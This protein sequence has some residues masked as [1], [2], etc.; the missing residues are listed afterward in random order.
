M[1][2]SYPND[3]DAVNAAIEKCAG[4]CDQEV[5]RLPAK[6]YSHIR[7]EISALAMK[8][9]A[10]KDRGVIQTRKPLPSERADLNKQINTAIEKCASL[11]DRESESF[12]ESARSHDE[13]GNLEEA[14][15][16]FRIC[17]AIRLLSKKMRGMKE[18]V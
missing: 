3:A 1:P 17:D 15:L 8:I 18:A 16:H 6:S 10:L 5:E 12:D 9:R 7:D 13:D 11:C 2:Q 4:L 14:K